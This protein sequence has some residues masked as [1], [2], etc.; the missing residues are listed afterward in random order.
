[1]SE[2]QSIENVFYNRVS[3]ELLDKYIGKSVVLLGKVRKVHPNGSKWELET[4]DGR[5]VSISMGMP[6]SEELSGFVEVRGICQSPAAVFCNSYLT[7]PPDM[8]GNFE[9][10]LY[11]EAVKLVNTV[12]NPWLAESG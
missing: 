4:T 1:M 12:P 8:T 10:D 7:F 3:G 2:T 11:N 5:V 6:L 9:T